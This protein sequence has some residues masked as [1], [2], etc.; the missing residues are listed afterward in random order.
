MLFGATPKDLLAA[1][2]TCRNTNTDI[3]AQIA[4][5]RHYVDGLAV[6]YRGPAALQLYALSQ[7][8]G[9][10]ADQLNFV[11]STIADRLTGNSNNYVQHETTNTTSLA[12]IASSLPTA[13]L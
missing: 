8:W 3:Q 4:R 13:R 2:A 11:L 12:G 7:Q 9:A 5:M 6:R 10:D 1:A